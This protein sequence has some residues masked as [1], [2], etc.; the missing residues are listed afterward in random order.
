[1]E[2]AFFL[3]ASAFLVFLNGFF[4]LA[5]FAAVKVRPT[6]V[7]VL[8]DTGDK[9]AIRALKVVKNLDVYLSV[10][11]VGIT[12][13]SVGLGF[14]GEPAFTEL[15]HPVV[16]FFG[17]GIL[18]ETAAVGVAVFL[19][20]VII[21]FLHIVL[22]ELLPK[23]IAIRS[24]EKSV[25]AISGPLIAFRLLFAGPI[26]F[27]NLTVNGLLR[28]LGFP[29]TTGHEAHSD[30]EIRAILDH[31]EAAGVLPFRSLL[32]LE[33]VLDFSSL[34]VRNAMRPKRLV[35]SLSLPLTREEARENA[36]KTKYSR[37]PVLSPSGNPIGFLHLKDL[38]FADPA[39]SIDQLVRPLT[40]V[41]ENEPLE[42]V[43]T[44]MQRRGCHLAQVFSPSG[45]W[46][47]II[48]LEDVVEELTGTIEEEYPV[49]PPVNLIEFLTPDRVVLDVQG[50]SVA[51]AVE[52]G[53]SSLSPEHLPCKLSDIV[54][55]VTERERLGGS[56]VG[57][58][59]SIPHARL[60]QVSQPAVFV[61]RLAVPLPAPT[62]KEGEVIR[63]LFL[64]ITPAASH[65]VHQIFLS[66]IG[67]MFDSDYLED[68]LL[69]ATSRQELF[70]TIAAVE[71]TALS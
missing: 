45:L 21:S 49:E 54:L 25:L 34:T 35:H 6:Q 50:T 41:E 37:Y 59:L 67:G 1:M 14:V 31:S 4:V 58:Q 12:V 64:L 71:L 66:H 62:G 47:G 52:K 22:G 57:H 51:E 69:E 18:A 55:A 42:K 32:L 48:T 11:Q 43:L 53:L 39:L 23:S 44:M 8:A 70:E 20:F 7:Q 9:R 10:C 46:T 63:L 38:F 3:L 15:L 40:R 28:L 24:P 27:L 61:F 33:N 5:E 13:A 26:W 68:R 60:E 30:G 29:R 56:Y 36:S 65:R 19:G 17:H 16:A 2:I